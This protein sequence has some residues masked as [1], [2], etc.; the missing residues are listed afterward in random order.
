LC[1]SFTTI[2]HKIIFFFYENKTQDKLRKEKSIKIRNISKKNGFCISMG[3][4]NIG[5]TDIFHTNL[6]EGEPPPP[7]PQKKK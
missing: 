2:K 5:I 4:N 3:G 6:I 7:T 1:D